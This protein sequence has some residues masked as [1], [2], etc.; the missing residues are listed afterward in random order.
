MPSYLFKNKVT[1][2]VKEVQMPMNAEHKYSEGDVEYERIFIAPTA[3]VDNRIDPF[4]K[5]GFVSKTASKRGSVGDLFD[6]SKELSIKR[7]EKAG[8]DSV[9]ENYYKN[10]ADKRRGSQHPDVRK[11]ESIKKLDKLGVVVE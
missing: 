8:R 6:M 11:V 2:E 7:E 5:R 9:K 10:Y 3:S 1:G 4:D